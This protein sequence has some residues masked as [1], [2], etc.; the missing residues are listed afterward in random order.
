MN[1]SGSHLMRWIIAAVMVLPMTMSMVVGTGAPPASARAAAT[2]D[3]LTLVR[4]DLALAPGGKLSIQFH[5]QT[6]IGDATVS[7]RIYKA[8]TLRESLKKAIAHDLSGYIDDASVTADEITTDAA[9]N[10]TIAV[11]T[12]GSTSTGAP[13]RL[14]D[15]GLYPVLVRVTSTSGE[16][17]GDLVSFVYRLPDAGAAP[18]GQISVAVLASITAAPSIGDT[19]TPLPADV[20]TQIAELA[21]YRSFVK[22]SL[23]MSPEILGRLDDLTRQAVSNVMANGVMLSQPVVPFDPSDATA[24]GLGNTLADLITAGEQSVVD[25]GG[26]PQP[27]RDAWYAP[28]GITDEAALQLRK[29]ATRVL[30][31]PSD[32]YLAATGNVGDYTDYS[33]LFQTVLAGGDD[34]SVD[35]TCGTQSMTCMPTA[36]VDPLLSSRFTDASLSDEQA[37]LYTAADVV[38]Y[39]EQLADTLSATNKHALVLGLDGDGVPNAARVSRAVEML[40]ATGAANFITLDK[41]QANSDALISDGRQIE[42]HLPQPKTTDLSK[43]KQDLDNVTLAAAYVSSMLDNDGGRS[44]EWA[45]TIQS[46]Y[47]TSLTDPQVDAAIDGVNA[48]LQKIKDCVVPPATYPFTLAGRST[49]LPLRITNTCQET[50]EVVV[51]LSAEAKKLLFPDGDIALALAPGITSFKVRVNA[52]TNGSFKVFLHVF[53]PGGLL[54]DSGYDVTDPVTL[55]ARVNALTGLPQLITGVGVLLLLTWWA[56]NQRR[57]RRQRRTIASRTEHPATKAEPA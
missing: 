40:T 56:R 20:S 53:S 29:L 43:R 16:V 22:I 25:V 4:Q 24:S 9:G 28:H 23:A 52:R 57:S 47:S 50:L 34:P 15:A 10:V 39:R 13:L 12:D 35:Q 3:P 54:P 32:V 11:L 1:S 14:A 48:Q 5:P 17:I 21:R 19:T 30:V 46:L 42:L 6:P 8:V 41:L 44:V 18:L 31:I 33:Q 2:S 7:V 38:V 49:S 26:F 36:V 27:T 51:R 37:A 45:S 55:R